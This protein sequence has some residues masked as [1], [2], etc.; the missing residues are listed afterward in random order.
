MPDDGGE[1]AFVHINAFPGRKRRPVENDLISFQLATDKQGRRRAENIQF[2]GA[3][4][5]PNEV[6]MGLVLAL[7]FFGLVIVLT[8]VGKLPY[9]VS[10]LYGTASLI[11]FVA[12]GFDK[13]AARNNRSRIPESTLHVFGLVGGWP[14]A[15]LAQKMFRH[16]SK[17]QSFQTVFWV[18]VFINCCAFAWLFS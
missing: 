2:S 1:Q 12:Y 3:F 7:L 8:M 4:F 18:T 16:K 11:T 5:G 6:P 17:K 15:V 10:G 14:G 9:N 13:L